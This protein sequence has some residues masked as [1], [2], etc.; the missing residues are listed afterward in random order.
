M[1]CWFREGRWLRDKGTWL[2]L[3]IGWIFWDDVGGARGVERF[4]GGGDDVGEDVLFGGVGVGVTVVVGDFG[5]VGYA[6]GYL[7]EEFT[8]L[9]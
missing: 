2:G 5:E 8:F 7:L 1:R 9:D 3:A 6:I 4:A